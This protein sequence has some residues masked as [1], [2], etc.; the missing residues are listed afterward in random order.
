[1]GILNSALDRLAAAIGKRIQ[2]VQPEQAYSDAAGRG[3][4]G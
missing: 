4:V 3:T 2:G 1:M